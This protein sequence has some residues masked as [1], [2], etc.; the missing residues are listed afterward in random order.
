MK[1]RKCGRKM[2]FFGKE[3]VEFDKQMGTDKVHKS[4]VRTYGCME[5]A[6]CIFMP[7]PKQNFFFWSE[8]DGKKMTGFERIE[9]EVD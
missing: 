3:R 9:R 2:M 6:S 4:T 7:T 5:D 1:C 8:A